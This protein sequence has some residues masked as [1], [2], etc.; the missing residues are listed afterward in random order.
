MFAGSE[1]AALVKEGWVV[2]SGWLSHP[3]AVSNKGLIHFSISAKTFR[4]R[5]CV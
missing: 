3:H 4:R 1:E 2:V 5:R